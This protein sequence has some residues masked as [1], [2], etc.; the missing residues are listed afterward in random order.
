MN[1]STQPETYAFMAF[2]E[3]RNFVMSCN[4]HGGAEVCNYPWDY[5]FDFCADDAW[6]QFVCHEYADTAHLYSPS[7]YMDS[8]QFDN[9]ITNG[10]AW[11]LIHGGRQDY[12]NYFHQCR[13]F[14][15]ELS[16]TKLLSESLLPAYWG[17]NYRSLLNY[18]EQ[19]L[20]GIR[21]V[22]TDA[23]TGLPIEAEVYILNHEADSS[24]VYSEI[25]TGNYHRL[26]N[27]GTYNVRFSSHCYEDQ[28]INNVVVNNYSTTILD[29]QLVPSIADFTAS[30]TMVIPGI[31]LNQD[32][33]CRLLQLL[34]SLP[35]RRKKS[36]DHH[37]GRDPDY[38]AQQSSF[39]LYLAKH[40]VEY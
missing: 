27:E 28:I 15:L 37:M 18:M 31:L 25:Q 26:V 32:K 17:Y 40:L 34:C 33:P 24:W 35:F 13:E 9:G 16:N 22:I 6:W 3:N 14:T 11:Y 10:A 21:G 38:I 4:M 20:Y 1:P 30:S 39:L 8:P 19:C 29:I 23:N 36:G 7:G 12:M 2:E 5:K